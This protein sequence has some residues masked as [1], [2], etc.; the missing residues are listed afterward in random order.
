MAYVSRYV[1][2]SFL[3]NLHRLD[4]DLEPAWDPEKCRWIILWRGHEVMMVQTVEGEYAPLDN[5][6]LQKLFA[7]DTAR[8]A[9]QAQFI[10]N[11]H[12]DD[13]R[14]YTKKRREQ[15]EYM[16]SI[17]R[18]MLPFLKKRR[19]VTASKVME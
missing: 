19:T 16:R 1:D 15:D 11:L 18:D 4:P 12:L 9:T 3:A 7:A 13:D 5:R 10:Y 2:P 17:H 8:Y 14:I 6:I